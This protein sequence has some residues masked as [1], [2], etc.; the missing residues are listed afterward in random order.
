MP[1]TKIIEFPEHRLLIDAKELKEIMGVSYQAIKEWSRKGRLKHIQVHV[2]RLM[3][4]DL[5][6]VKNRIKMGKVLDD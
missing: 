6:K 2:G 1:D 4:Y 3:K 5:E